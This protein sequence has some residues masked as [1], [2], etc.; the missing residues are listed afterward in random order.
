MRYHE[1][2]RA[3]QQRAGGS[4]VAERLLR[5][6]GEE[7]PEPAQ[8]FVAQQR[9]LILAGS[10]A[11]GRVW[12]TALHGEPGF[13]RALAPGT[14]A[15]A[16]RPHPGDPLAA[17]LD[18]GPVPVGLLAIEPQTRRRM[19]VNGLGTRVE[20]GL[21]VHTRQVYA[22]CP[23]YIARREPTGEA[24]AAAPVAE[25]RDALAAADVELVSGADTFFI[26]STGPG[27][28]ADAS[29][30]GGTPGFVLVD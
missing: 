8:A 19:R 27:G 24:A 9:L 2:Q 29:H 1:G 3:V 5:G 15:I 16:A 18:S 30:R 14:L 11:D 6:T 13:A 7:L 23:K 10:D 12:A 21:Q 22:N 17:T 28:A 25:R 26:A 4:E 20:G